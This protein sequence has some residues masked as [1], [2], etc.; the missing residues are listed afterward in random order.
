MVVGDVMY[1]GVDGG[2]DEGIVMVQ[3][4]WHKAR[5]INPCQMLRH[6]RHE[7]G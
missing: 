1:R 5:G 4:A 3:L 2:Y 7:N 6:S